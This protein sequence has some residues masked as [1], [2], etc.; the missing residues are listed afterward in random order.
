MLPFFTAQFGNASSPHAS[1]RVAADAVET[2]RA[3]VAQLVGARAR[4]IV[5]TSGATESNNL[6]LLG[7]ARAWGDKRRRIVTTA[8]EHKAVLETCR[9]LEK[10][11]FELIIVP[12]DRLGTV[13]LEAAREAINEQTLLVSIQAANHEIGTIQPV[14]EIAALAHQRGAFVH[15]DAA[16]AAGKIALDAREWD[17]DLL[18]LS[19]HKMYGPKGVGALWV[20]GGK[21]AGLSPLFWGG[22]QEN[23]LRPG[24]LN[25]P[26]IVGLGE[27]CQLCHQ[28][29]NQEASRLSNLRD[30]FEATLCQ[31]MPELKRNGNLSRRLPHNSSLTFTG[32]EAEALLANL[33][34][35]ALSTGSACTSGALE[36]SPVLSAIGLTRDEGYATVRVGLGR[37]T[38]QQEMETAARE[39]ARV[40]AQLRVMLS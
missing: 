10:Q 35:L 4:E 37:F 26:G 14:R 29:M 13:D 33:P 9:E 8:V 20:R 6:A 36:P 22:D 3:Q 5:F 12:V 40:T 16:Q 28:E 7:L 15:C 39:I 21:R 24:T 25:V 34:N 19:A 1:G 23:G 31:A 17:V 18:S 2:A 32:M 27:A 11:G 38:T 30:S